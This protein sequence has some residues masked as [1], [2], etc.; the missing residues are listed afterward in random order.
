MKPDRKS[1]LS[2]IIPCFNE[3]VVIEQT[4]RQLCEVLERLELGYELIYVDDGS[5][6][7]TPEILRRFREADEHVRVLRLSRNFGHQMAITAGMEHASGDA[8]VVIDA[9]LQDPPE[10][11][12]EMVTKWLEGYHVVYG[13]RTE[14]H[15]ETEF[16]LWTA[17]IFYRLINRLSKV[18]IPL[19]AGDF[20]LL[21]R[22]VVNALRA[23][24]ER[25]RF[26]RGLVSW[27]GFRQVAVPYQRAPRLTGESKYSFL[28][29]MRFAMDGI[30]SFSL[31]PL[32]FA[33]WAGFLSL[34]LAFAG[35]IYALVI[36]LFTENVV[37]GWTTI[38]MA[39]LFLGGVQLIC[40]GIIGEYVGRNY[41][42]SKRR[43]LY[44]IQEGLGFEE[45]NP[46]E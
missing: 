21:D 31:Y 43:P 25:D 40:L 24:S 36:R 13:L 42:E 35:I 10:V 6:D 5:G 8:V 12:P 38:I 3:E 9:D 19:D 34:G 33:T 45:Q 22:K 46:E 41:G 18:K 26:V 23:M 11:I 20:R 2:I 44:I 32:R 27:A 17:K 15:G 1:L 14:R 30:F 28:K 37:S 39:V 29:M 4:Q 16:K 7:G